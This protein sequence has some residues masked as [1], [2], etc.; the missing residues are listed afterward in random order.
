MRTDL[1]GIVAQDFGDTSNDPTQPNYASPAY[2]EMA[3]RWQVCRDARASTIEIRKKAEYY[4]PRFEAESIQDWQARL[5]L[6]FA[7]NDFAETINDFIGMILGESIKLGDDV[8]AALRLLM[9]DVDG[10]GNHLDVFAALALE[11]M[12]EQ[13]HVVLLTDFPRSTGVTN[14]LQVLTLP[15]RPYVTLYRASDVLSWRSATVGGTQ[16]LTQIVLRERAIASD[17]TFGITPTT[18]IRRLWQDVQIDEITGRATS[19]GAMHWQLFERPANPAGVLGV[20][21]AAQP[22][23]PAFTLAA[24]GDYSGPGPARLPVRVAYAGERR[25]LLHTVPPLYGLALSAIEETQ[26]QSEYATT[27][28]KCNVPTPVFVGRNGGVGDA[29]QMGVGLDL[30]IGASAF[31]LEPK[32][33]A[34]K[35]T[36]DRLN[37]IHMRMRRQG[38]T[39]DDT[40][41]RTMTATEADLYARQRNAKMLRAARGLQDAI[42][43][44]LADF[45]A[46]LKLGGKDALRAGGSVV[47]NTDF[48]GTSIN[49]QLAAVVLDAAKAGLIPLDA[50]HYFLEKGRLPDDF[51]ATETALKLVAQ[52]MPTDGEAEPDPADANEDEDAQPNEEPTNDI[53]DP[54][55]GT[56][57]AGNGNVGVAA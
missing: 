33:T 11:A 43:G 17:D 3:P 27:M 9:E 40:S 29:V 21:P 14:H 36:V 38:A 54:E 10:E 55:S 20:D 26:V 30:P 25:G 46:F 47:V 1:L 50:F 19:L 42:E 57:N 8:P 22:S 24:E 45:A 51:S 53:G 16:V 28:H 7:G 15:L 52:Q 39:M 18:R 56:Q 49:P 6:T 4:L 35:A 2:H 5:G 34:L 31:Y 23:A 12:F 41:H 37:D 32:G 48:A 44:M 13:G